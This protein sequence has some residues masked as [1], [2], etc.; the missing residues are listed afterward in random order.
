MPFKWDQIRKRPFY[1]KYAWA[2][3]ELVNKP[4]KENSQAIA[5]YLKKHFGT[6]EISILDAGCGPGGYSHYLGLHGFKVLGVDLSEYQLNE[7]KK[8]NAIPNVTYQC[9]N[10]LDLDKSLKYN[11]ILSRGVL[12]DITDFKLREKVL[13]HFHDLLKPGGLLLLDV[14]NW[15][16]SRDAIKE[17]PKIKR[18]VSLPKGRLEFTSIRTL[19]EKNE[20]YDLVETHRLIT[21]DSIHSESF[22]F[23]MICSTE[24]QLENQLK[25]AGFNSPIFYGYYDFKT[26]VKDSVYIISISEK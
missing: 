16:N 7:A 21:D 23:R 5:E 18:T 9:G 4:V 12:N 19:D 20:S 14:R 11:V 22:N 24:S 25:K 3:E 8:K 13:R 26:P 17:N 2:Y 15:E 1:N 6:H 10:F